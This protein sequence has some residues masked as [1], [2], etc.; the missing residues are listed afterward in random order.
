MRCR[1]TTDRQ[2]RSCDLRRRSSC[3]PV[4]VNPRCPAMGRRILA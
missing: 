4:E 1:S 3:S 2:T